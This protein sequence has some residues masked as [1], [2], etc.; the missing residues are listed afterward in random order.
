MLAE[1][2]ERRGHLLDGPH[3]LTRYQRRSLQA[4][5]GLDPAVLAGARSA[6]EEYRQRVDRHFRDYDVVATTAMATTAFELGRRPTAVAGRPVER[7]WG[8][9]PFAVPFNVS[10]HPAVVLPV[11][12]VNGLP[13]AIQLAGRYGADTDLLVLAE[14]LEAQLELSPLTLLKSVSAP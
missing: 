3:E 14:H 9:F 5:A 13:A 1:E 6:Q 8:A 7:L 12:L 11:G 10:G 4:A 2:G